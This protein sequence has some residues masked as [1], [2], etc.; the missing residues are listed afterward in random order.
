MSHTIS[1]PDDVYT[2]LAR[3]AEQEGQPVEAVAEAL[4][5]RGLQSD[6]KVEPALDWETASAEEIIADLRASRVERERLIE[7]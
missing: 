5:N 1:V 6:A 2:K 7:L 4:L 3:L